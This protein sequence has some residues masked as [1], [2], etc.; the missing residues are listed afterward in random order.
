L[1]LITRSIVA[2]AFLI[3]LATPLMAQNVAIKLQPA[4][5][6]VTVIPKNLTT[7]TITTSMADLTIYDQKTCKIICATKM[8]IVRKLEPC[9]W[10]EF[11]MCCGKPMLVPNL[12]YRVRLYYSGGT[13]EAWAFQ[14]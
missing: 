7:S 10:Q 5:N 4:Q 8:K 3:G 12:I 2:S 1:K 6:C 11:K 13:D 9:I 14:P